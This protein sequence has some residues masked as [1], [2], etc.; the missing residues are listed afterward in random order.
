MI[1]GKYSVDG[2]W[3]YKTKICFKKIDFIDLHLSVVLQGSG[4]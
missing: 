1:E 3:M 2:I 4:N